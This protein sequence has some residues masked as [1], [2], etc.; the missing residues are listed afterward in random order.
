MLACSTY[1]TL[2]IDKQLYIGVN[3][4]PKGK[5]CF[6]VLK[7]YASICDREYVSFFEAIDVVKTVKRMRI[8]EE[9]WELF[10]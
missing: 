5:Q 4:P 3:P 2:H 8:P 9:I 1:V 7:R 10:L 6:Y